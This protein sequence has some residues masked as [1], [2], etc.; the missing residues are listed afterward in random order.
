[1]RFINCDVLF[2]GIKTSRRAAS[3]FS[4]AVQSTF[5]AAGVISGNSSALFP[6]VYTVHLS[7]RLSRCF[8]KAASNPDPSMHRPVTFPRAFRIG[9]ADSRIYVRCPLCRAE[10]VIEPQK[11][12]HPKFCI[13]VAVV[14]ISALVK[15][16]LD[17]SQRTIRQNRAGAHERFH[18][19]S[20]LQPQSRSTDRSRQDRTL[21]RR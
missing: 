2:A 6:R 18:H 14:L 12:I 9:E 17:W 19:M 5:F 20:R 7:C 10:A 8:K 11:P 3:K 21:A 15:H 16:C 1:M 4:P 13:M